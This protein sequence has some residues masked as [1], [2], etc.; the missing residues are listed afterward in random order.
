MG[1]YAA[2]VPYAEWLSLA[3]VRALGSSGLHVQTLQTLLPIAFH[4]T[5]RRPPLVCHVSLVLSHTP[6]AQRA[7]YN[8]VEGAASALVTLLLVRVCTARRPPARRR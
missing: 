5:P 1:R 7:H 4:P 8:Y 3:N 6:Q 2:L